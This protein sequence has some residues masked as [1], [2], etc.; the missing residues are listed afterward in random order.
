MK[1]V[2][3]EQQYTRSAA[4]NSTHDYYNVQRHLSLQNPQIYIK[5]IMQFIEK[6]YHNMKENV[7]T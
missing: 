6:T 5:S 3:G 7:G 2:R 4:Q 1:V